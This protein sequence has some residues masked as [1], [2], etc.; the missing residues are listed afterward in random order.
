MVYV[1][2]KNS[3]KEIDREILEK[4]EKTVITEEPI[5]VLKGES[6]Y[7]EQVNIKEI[8]LDDLKG[9]EVGNEIIA[10][11]NTVRD[12]IQESIKVLYKDE[13]GIL[14]LLTQEY[15]D[16]KELSP[17]TSWDPDEVKY[18]LIYFKFH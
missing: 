16:D 7:S 18:E 3:G 11:A 8:Y 17:Y 13:Q 10:Y 12:A 5:L 1:D 6:S 15:W 9:L 14:L 2:I 4:A